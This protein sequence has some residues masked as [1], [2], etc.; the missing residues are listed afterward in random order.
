MGTY[1]YTGYATGYGAYGRGLYKREA[2]AEASYYGGYGLGS[3]GAG[4]GAGY[5]SGYGYALPT[6]GYTGYATGYGAYGRGLYK[7]EA[8]A[9]AS[10]YGAGYGSGYGSGYGYGLP[11]YGYTGYATGYGAYGLDFTSVRLMPRL[12]TMEAMVLDP[13]V[14]DMVPA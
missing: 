4:Y 8:D 1:G 13:M 5:G 11:T 3:Y 2:D 6:Y 7:R 10:S 14:L 9:E 12:P